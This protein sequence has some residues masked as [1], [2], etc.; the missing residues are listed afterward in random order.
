MGTVTKDRKRIGFVWDNFGPLHADRCN[1][2]VQTGRADVFGYQIFARSD[3]YEWEAPPTESFPMRTLFASGGWA[4][5]SNLR[6]AHCLVESVRADGCDAV[7]MAHYDQLAILLASTQLGRGGTDVFTM[8]CS[9]YDDAPRKPW[10]EWV[11]RQFYRPYAGGIGSPERSMDYMR[12]LGLPPD[13]VEAGYNTVDQDRIR[14]LAQRRDG[15][16]LG[17]DRRSFLIVARLIPQKNFETL[18]RS[19]RQ[20]LA[21]VEQPRKLVIAGSGPLERELKGLAA[22]LRIDKHLDWLGFVQTERVAQLMRD[23][24]C[25]VLPSV[26]ETFGNV[27]PEALAVE[28]PVLVSTQC[29]AVD[30][31]VVDSINGFTFA[32]DDEAKLADLLVRL[33]TDQ[34]L[35]ERLRNGAGRL[36]PRGDTS[37][38]ARSVL[39]L[40]S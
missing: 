8:G 29:G 1:A 35:W 11:K 9:K 26:S 7:F 38:F 25:L 12:Q 34:G 27:I 33:G 37:V 5:H 20:Y 32:P 40:V 15:A 13:R 21:R 39:E 6:L 30:H 23:A 2:V 18:F 4:E 36:A 16:D 14:R 31:L 19:Y 24:L 3:L 17:Y 28:L 10:R 22:D